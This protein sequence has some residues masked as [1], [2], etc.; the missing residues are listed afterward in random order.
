LDS[1]GDL[2]YTIVLK[3]QIS[4]GDFSQCVGSSHYLVPSVSVEL[5]KCHRRLGHLSFHLLS[6]LSGLGLV[7]GLPKLNT[8][9][10]W[11]VLHV[12]MVTWSPPLTRL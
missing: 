2:L 7:R 9:R 1:Q 4:R 12:G 10:I 5:W 3:G 8:K 11:Y 6:C